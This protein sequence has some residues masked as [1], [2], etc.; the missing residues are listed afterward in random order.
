MEMWVMTIIVQSVGFAIGLFK[1]WS[2][3]QVKLKELD[4][5][6]SSVE[7]QDD[8]IYTKLDRMMDKLVAIEIALNNKADR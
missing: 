3:L 7:K 1:I 4:M 5:R 8:E 2:D 6:L